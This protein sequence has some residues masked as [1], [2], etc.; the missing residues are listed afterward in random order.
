MEYTKLVASILLFWLLSLMLL[1][2]LINDSNEFSYNSSSNNNPNIS[3][4]GMCMHGV[5]FIPIINVVFN[6]I[7]WKQ[8]KSRLE[9]FCEIVNEINC[10]Q[11]LYYG[12]DFPEIIKNG[13]KKK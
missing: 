12:S 4:N 8:G 2:T 11:K 9:N 7:L 13:K 1:Y 6:F 10:K 3:V 5:Y